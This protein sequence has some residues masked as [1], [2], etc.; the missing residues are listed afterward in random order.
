MAIATD[1][2]DGA[3]ATIEAQRALSIEVDSRKPEQFGL[4]IPGVF[5]ADLTDAETGRLVARG[6]KRAN[7]YTIYDAENLEDE[8]ILLANL[9]LEFNEALRRVEAAE[10]ADR[11]RP[12][13]QDQV[14]ASTRLRMTWDQ[15]RKPWTR[16]NDAYRGWRRRKNI[17]PSRPTRTSGAA[18]VRRPLLWDVRGGTI[19]GS[20][21]V[22]Y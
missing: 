10:E 5:E 1:D 15:S 13:D 21:T 11:L 12:G 22:I 18:C 4:Q 14:K 8:R 20:M 6:C 9:Q 19:P 3:L 2:R 7:R 16:R 17:C